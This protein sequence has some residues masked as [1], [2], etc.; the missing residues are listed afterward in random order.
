MIQRPTPGALDLELGDPRRSGEESF[1]ITATD[2]FK[3]LQSL[4]IFC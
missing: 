1:A 4:V 2:I 3:H